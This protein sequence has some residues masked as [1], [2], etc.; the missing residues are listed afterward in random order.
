MQ[1]PSTSRKNSAQKKVNIELLPK[2]IL[3]KRS[4]PATDGVRNR[5]PFVLIYGLDLV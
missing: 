3:G 1:K 4:T 5:G 2:T